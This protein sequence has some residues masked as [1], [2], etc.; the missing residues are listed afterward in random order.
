M[1]DVNDEVIDCM[2]SIHG[3]TFETL[4]DVCYW[5]FGMTCE[6]MKEELEE[7]F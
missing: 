2:C 3:Y 1:C 5:K 4:D 6:Q 7:E